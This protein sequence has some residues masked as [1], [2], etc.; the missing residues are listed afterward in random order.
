MD[1][2]RL[3]EVIIGESAAIVQ[4]RELIATLAPGDL[5]VLIH[6]PTGSGKELVARAL[7]ELSGKP[8]RFVPINVCAIAE[9]MF[10]DA[11]FG[12]VKGAFTG[13]MG[14]A[15][16]YLREANLGTVF[17]DEIGSLPLQAQPKLLRAI[18]S[19][20]FRPVGAE[21]DV[22][23]N[24]RVVSA[25]NEPLE[26]LVQDG[27]FRL[28]LLFRLRGAVI[29]VPP[30]RDRIEDLPLLAHYF[31]TPLGN[32]RAWRL[33]PEALALLARYRWPG[34]V[35]ELRHA[36]AWASNLAA[37][38]EIGRDAIARV[39]NAAEFNG[40]RES[41]TSRK[42]GERKRLRELLE[43]CDWDTTRVAERLGVHRSTVYRRMDRLGIEVP[44]S[45]SQRYLHRRA[46]RWFMKS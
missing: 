33:N 22:S 8:G 2:D 7:H 44:E 36:L 37:N 20:E 18:E 10:E 30:L 29:H 4:L 14:K 39:L 31:L 1:A 27:R 6:G 11:F 3:R 16:G 40:N 28:D 24:F 26:R 35:R 5:P 32:G 15:D 34:N 19:G 45:A 21:A 42:E 12:H 38:G 43:R 46:T 9:G 25:T 17:L 41:D 23:S 13:S